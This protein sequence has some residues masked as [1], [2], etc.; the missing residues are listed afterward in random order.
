MASVAHSCI[1]V[2]WGTSNRRAWA[3]GP[4]DRQATLASRPEGGAGAAV[5]E[6]LL[7]DVPVRGAI[8]T[9]GGPVPGVVWRLSTGAPAFWAHGPVGLWLVP[10]GPPVTRLGTTPVFPLVADAALAES[11]SLVLVH[12]E[13]RPRMASLIPDVH[14]ALLDMSLL[15]YGLAHWANDNPELV[16]DTASLV[17]VTGPSRTGDIELILNL[18]V[19][20]PRHVHIVMIK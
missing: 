17:I 19:H 4:E 1:A 14:V 6:H 7:A 13:G 15:A 2:D 5:P 18:G 16:A 8:R 9:A 11:G 10:L 12:G 3:L 20:G